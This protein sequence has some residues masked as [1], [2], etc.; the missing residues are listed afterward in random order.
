V[1]GSLCVFDRQPHE[2]SD[3][4]L[5]RAEETACAVMEEIEGGRT[6]AR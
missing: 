6:A 4:D 5:H 3:D 1:L 2:W